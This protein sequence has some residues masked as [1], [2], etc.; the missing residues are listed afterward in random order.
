MERQMNKKDAIIFSLQAENDGLYIAYGEISK[1]LKET[2]R[3]NKT[4]NRKLKERN[5]TKQYRRKDFRTGQPRLSD[6]NTEKSD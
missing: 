3:E 4:L 1:R 6:T 2:E 5:E